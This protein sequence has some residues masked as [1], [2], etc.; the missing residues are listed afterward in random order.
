MLKKF[1]GQGQEI[2][3]ADCKAGQQLTQNHPDV[4]PQ[5]LHVLSAPSNMDQ[6]AKTV[7]GHEVEQRQAHALI[8]ENRH[9]GLPLQKDQALVTVPMV[10]VCLRQ[11]FF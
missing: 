9:A 2:T 8:E 5:I 10:L 4:D 1:D 7:R 6:I 11:D 3:G